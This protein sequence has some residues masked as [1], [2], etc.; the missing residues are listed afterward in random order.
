MKRRSL[1]L[2]LAILSAAC[3]DR[4]DAPLDLPPDDP[5]IALQVVSLVGG[6]WSVAW[7]PVNGRLV[8]PA[9][10]GQ[11]LS[12]S[13]VYPL[14]FA[15]VSFDPTSPTSPDTLAKQDGGGFREL[16]IAATTGAVFYSFYPDHSLPGA[17]LEIR[18]VAAGGGTSTK[19]TTAEPALPDGFRVTPDEKR[20]ITKANYDPSRSSVTDLLTGQLVGS[21]DV[22]GLRAMSPD[23]EEVFDALPEER[24]IRISD[25]TQRQLN[26]RGNLPAAARV[27]DGAWLDGTLRLLVVSEQHELGLTRYTVLEWDEATGVSQTL[28]SFETGEPLTG[29]YCAGWSPAT[30]SAVLVADSVNTGLFDDFRSHY[31]LIAMAGGN[32]ITIGSVNTDNYEPSGCQLSPDGKWF[33]YRP[34]ADAV[35]VK[36]VK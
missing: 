18:R 20:L 5:G 32:S 30:H 35:Y 14:S 26:W 31:K 33:A 3:I 34:R 11:M 12:G 19:I 10:V 25:G 9:H 6:E 28:G 16:R 24:V 22:R 4:V 21:A 29:G 23:A 1:L 8:V 17:T 7:N 2:P 15:I 36:R 13:P 27:V